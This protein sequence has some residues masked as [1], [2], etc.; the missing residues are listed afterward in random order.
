MMI[1]TQSPKVR[2]PGALQP[3]LH[4]RV[5]RSH[6]QHCASARAIKS[7][8]HSEHAACK[9]TAF[10]AAGAMWEYQ[11]LDGQLHGPFSSDKMRQWTTKGY[12][13]SDLQVCIPHHRRDPT[14]CYMPKIGGGLAAAGA[15]GDSSTSQSLA[16]HDLQ[17]ICAGSSGRRVCWLVHSGSGDAADVGTPHAQAAPAAGG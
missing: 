4:K 2:L 5:R 14:D 11:D 10:V 17:G 16:L 8:T 13:Q 6:F 9:L 15:S 3:P 12:F 7:E 1:A